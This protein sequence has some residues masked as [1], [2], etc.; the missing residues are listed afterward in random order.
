M[1]VQNWYRFTRCQSGHEEAYLARFLYDIVYRK[2]SINFSTVI[3]AN[4]SRQKILPP[5]W[6][7]LPHSALV[8]YQSFLG[9][10]TNQLSYACKYDL[11]AAHD[12]AELFTWGLAEYALSVLRCTSSKQKFFNKK[13][14][15]A[16]PSELLSH[17][18]SVTREINKLKRKKRRLRANNRELSF[19]YANNLSQ[20]K[21]IKKS[22]SEKVLQFRSSAERKENDSWFRRN[23]FSFINSKLKHGNNTSKSAL[24]TSDI[25]DYFKKVCNPSEL[26]PLDCSWFSKLNKKPV[27]VDFN[28]SDIQPSDIEYILKEKKLSC[29]SGLDGLN[30][31]FLKPFPIIHRFLA[32][33]FNKI[34]KSG[35][36]C[37]SWQT[38][39]TIL[40]HK[41]GDVKSV[42]NYRPI[43][44]TSCVGKIFHS[45]ISKRLMTFCIKNGIIDTDVQKGFIEEMNGCGEHSLKLT[46]LI[47]QQRAKKRAMHVTWLDVANAYGSVRKE[48]M[49]AALKHYGIPNE[50]VNYIN[51]YYT[52]LS[53]KIQNNDSFTSE[54]PFNVGLFQGDT[55][56]CALFL[57]IFNPVL[58]FIENN[59]KHGIS[60]NSLPD[61]K[62]VALSFADDL[63]LI[64]KNKSTMQRLL[65]DVDSRMNS[66]GLRLQP[67]K[68]RS[69]SLK[70]GVSTVS[71]FS[72]KGQRITNI[73]EE[74]MKFLG[75]WIFE[76][77][78]STSAGSKLCEIFDDFLQRIDNLNLR[79]TFK[80]KIYKDYM[81]SCV[82]F[83][84]TVHDLSLSVVDQLESK[85]NKYIKKWIDLRDFTNC[86][87]FYSSDGLDLK[88]VK[89]IYLQA[90]A[91]FLADA[92]CSTDTVVS[93]IASNSLEKS[94]LSDTAIIGIVN[95]T[96]EAGKEA[97]ISK[98]KIRKLVSAKVRSEMTTRRD[99]RLRT[100]VQQGAWK[101]VA[102]A[103]AVDTFW[104]SVLYNLPEK[105]V[106]FM[107][108]AALDIAPSFTN[109]CK[110]GMSI[111][112]KC[113]LC[114]GESGTLCH[115]LNCCPIALSG[116]RYT[117]RHNSILKAIFNCFT[118][119]AV[120]EV[121][122]PFESEQGFSNADKRKKERYSRLCRDLDVAG[123][124][125]EYHHLAI[126]S[127]GMIPS[128]AVNAMHRIANTV[129]VGGKYVK[130]K[131][132]PESLASIALSCSY[133]IFLNKSNVNWAV[134]GPSE[135]FT[136]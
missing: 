27:T 26:A 47:E 98:G 71:E 97:G 62:L 25:E 33:L 58:E 121:T 116:A 68:C 55:M 67:S 124:T 95:N 43:T 49:L 135:L 21:V 70:K 22:L 34:L 119:A 41:K 84:L 87:Y 54:I 104:K 80:I 66:L 88:S 106:S 107:V 131:Q 81:T 57:L 93:V 117:W 23:M 39:K 28:S 96:V 118:S 127:R 129:A 110:W 109:L 76:K 52:G 113:D 85:V 18:S 31:A 111:S 130:A 74:P 75:A 2:L 63:T 40:I 112:A 1:D 69:F 83:L 73:S 12:I 65:N 20:L 108:K 78:Q 91:A 14:S 35:K 94:C 86:D 53:I 9:D 13:R 7:N 36:P 46:K 126:G 6:D 10:F 115:I 56:S 29:G 15:N 37:R 90:H 44:L 24:K 102:E 17:L 103:Q 136:Y 61:K 16:V 128:K 32:F 99:N 125:V 100:L 50:I 122:V 42:E 123:W 133:V 64:V 114:G 48:V 3:L 101:A 134:P 79:N 82:R 105:T 132:L 38:G 59:Q 30:Y 5:A 4:S 8:R 72:I 77:H 60:F 11:W 120:N 89:G 51:N 92:I 19:D 45:V